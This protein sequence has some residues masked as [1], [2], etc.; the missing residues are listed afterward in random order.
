MALAF[1]LAGLI[2]LLPSPAAAQD[3]RPRAVSD[4]AEKLAL[5]PLPE[6]RRTSHK[7][8]LFGRELSFVAEPGST[9]I[10]NQAGVRLAD[11][12]HVAYTL[13][14]PA[15]ASRPVV[16]A[17][18]G[19]PGSSSAWLHLGTLG[20]WR[21][22]LTADVIAGR[23]PAEPIDNGETWLKLADLVFI[24]PPGTGHSRIWPV[25]G[26][27]A[28][29]VSRGSGGPRWFWSVDGDIATF[30]EVI[31]R[32]LERHGRKG[33]PVVLVGESY[34]GFRGPL[35]AQ[36]LAK[37]HK[38]QIAG[39]VLV[40]PVLDFDG[41]RG[42]RTPIHYV[43][44]LPSIAATRLERTGTTPTRALLAEAEAYASGAYLADLIR[45]PRDLAAVG[46]MS[47]QVARLSGVPVEAVRGHAGRLTIGS[48]LEASPDLKGRGVS[49]YD[50]GMVGL[51]PPRERRGGFSD[52][53]TS[54]LDGPLTTAMGVVHTRLDWRPDR[55]YHVMSRE[56]NRAWIWPNT[57][58]APQATAALHQLHRNNQR[59]V[60]LVTHGFA[61]LVTPYFASVL[62]LDQLPAHGAQ[63]RVSLEVYP[64]GHMYYSRDDSRAW[65][66]ADGARLIEQ[67]LGR[68]AVGARTRNP[69]Q[70]GEAP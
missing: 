9:A 38:V 66:L 58:S 14:D 18:N 28:Q 12:A 22:P 25:Q 54:G 64:G 44:L 34:G 13:D 42:W 29:E 46:R 26:A 7:V 8:V 5:T 32:W 1:R 19:G 15:P 55:P 30:A 40:S 35:V 50:A 33:S 70:R 68:P 48:F 57:P 51:E 10:Q 60:T 53:F 62:H 21:L 24:D 43:K 41:R 65:F 36:A 17:F 39:M 31:A 3:A 52:P 23:T 16:F 61:D 47:E 20:P 69:E 37:D 63:Q 49:I 45:G 59:L 27:P 67:V 11:I 6:G 56:T 2:A 4:A